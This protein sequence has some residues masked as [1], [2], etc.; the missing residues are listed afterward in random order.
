[1]QLERYAVRL[2]MHPSLSV[3]AHQ[4]ESTHE[5]RRAFLQHLATRLDVATASGTVGGDPSSVA[6]GT[7]AGG[8][9][10]LGP[11]WS[12]AAE[13][14]FRAEVLASLTA[15]AQPAAGNGVT[16]P[17]VGLG[18][19]LAAGC[20]PS[21]GVWRS[22]RI[23][24]LTIDDAPWF[25]DEVVVAYEDVHGAISEPDRSLLVSMPITVTFTYEIPLQRT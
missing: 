22:F 15:S 13:T 12:S 2:Y 11:V 20:A 5:F 21:N 7:P 19:A 8:D 16:A 14:R 10:P 24:G 25:S 6:D 3:S 1:M 17:V 18:A 9:P 23:Y 4:I